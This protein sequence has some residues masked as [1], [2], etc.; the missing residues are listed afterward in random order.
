MPSGSARE[1]TV[2]FAD[3]SGST[4]LY[5][6]AG[7]ARALEG[8]RNCIH[9]LRQIAEL[10]AGRVVK[11]MGD[12]VLVLFASPSEA[13]SA[14]ARMHVAIES[15][16]PIGGT[17]LAVR[18][19]FNWGPVIQ[20]QED[21][22]GDTVNLAFRIVEQA[23]AGEILTSEETAGHL[24]PALRSNARRLHPIQ[25]KG[26]AVPVVLWELVWRQSPDVTDMATTRSALKLPTSRLVLKYQGR[27]LIR[28]RNS[29]TL[30]IG[31]D[32]GCHLVIEDQKASRQ[33]CTIEKR[34][35][36][37]ILKDHSTNGTFVTVEGESEIVLQREDVTLRKRGWITF[38]QRRA[39]TTDVVE[40]ECE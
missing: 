7:D 19:G 26:K 16:P 31:R 25:V 36:K 20:E 22:F 28:R 3:V 2:L 14:A 5:E 32:A 38:G 37:F 24:V 4:K 23:R 21:V 18:I 40:Y 8:I 29:E 10:S 6:T 27:D 17:R 13:A 9:K 35:D 33:H 39:E 12:A 11:T 15:L 30:V 1:T 34:L